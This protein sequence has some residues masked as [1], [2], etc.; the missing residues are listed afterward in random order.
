MSR[1]VLLGILFVVAVLGVLIYSSLQLAKHQVQVCMQF[2]GKTNCALA[3]GTSRDYA[4]RA[5]TSNAC[6]TIASGVTDTMACERAQPVSVHWI[7]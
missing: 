5:A 4:L 2:N 3:S 7:K 6:A 1:P